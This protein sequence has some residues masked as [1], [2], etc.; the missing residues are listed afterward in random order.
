MK[1]NNFLGAFGLGLLIGNIIGLSI[2]EVT[3]ILLGAL[4]SILSAFFGLRTNYNEDQR[5]QVFLATFCITCFIAIFLGIY[6]RTYNLLSPS[7]AYLIKKNE[8]IKLDEEE[9]K[10]LFFYKEF[11]ILPNGYTVLNKDVQNNRNTFL[12]AGKNSRLDMCETINDLNS[13][14]DIITSFNESGD[15]YGKIANQLSH[16]IKDTSELKHSLLILKKIICEN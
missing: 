2:S 16:T 7:L 12:M 9:I 5:S 15:V 14:S 4:T 1:K 10:N 8:N 3:G 13:L 11:G 6:I